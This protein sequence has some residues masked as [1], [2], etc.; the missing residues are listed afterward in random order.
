[1]LAWCCEQRALALAMLTLCSRVNRH[2]RCVVAS[3]LRTLPALDFRGHEERMTGPEILTALS[4]VASTNLR[5]VDLAACTGIMPADVARILERVAATCPGVVEIN[6]TG[7]SV[8]V[9]LRA[10]AVRVQSVCGADSP[11]ALF[12][13]ISALQEGAA[14]YPLS[15][16]RSLLLQGPLNL[17]FEF[18]PGRDALLDAAKQGGGWEAALLLSLAYAVETDAVGA[19]ETR[20]FDSNHEDTGRRRAVHVAA[21]R[22]DRPLLTVLITAGAPLNVPDGAGD[23]PLLL[24]L[25]V[26]C[27]VFW[28][29]ECASWGGE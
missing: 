3:V 15:S 21:M 12:E 6:V 17:L 26:F 22:G 18:V 19:S 13:F 24:A 2:W 29:E 14:R 23:T 10:L 27:G 25:R 11:R 9:Q 7:C 1:M 4:R 8:Q 16:L 5:L 20:T 28:A